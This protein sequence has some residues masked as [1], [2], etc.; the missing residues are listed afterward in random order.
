M[1]HEV[2]VQRAHASP[3][4]PGEGMLGRWARAAL[5]RG[6]EGGAV[7]LRLVDEAE[8]AELNRRYRGRE[9]ATNVLSF[10]F[11]AAE[12]TDPP[13]LGDVVICVPVVERE[14][15]AQGK[16]AESHYAHMVVHGVLHLLGHDHDDDG[17]AREMETLETHLLAALGFADPYRVAQ[18]T[19]EPLR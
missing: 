11:E 13:L 16:S 3:H 10:P 4:T 1:S 14:A 9:G 5:A 8:G 12:F 6:C 18:P 7:S 15:C 17:A 19:S 2:D